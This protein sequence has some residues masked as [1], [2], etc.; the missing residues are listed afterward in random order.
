MTFDSDFCSGNLSKVVK[1]NQ[2]NEYLL[3]VSHDGAPYLENG[4]KTWFYFSVKGVP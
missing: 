1:G 2:K 4:Y 3:W